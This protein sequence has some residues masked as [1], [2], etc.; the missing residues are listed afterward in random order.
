M[1]INS[2]MSLTHIQSSTMAHIRIKRFVKSQGPYP[3]I[4]KIRGSGTTLKISLNFELNLTEP[5]PCAWRGHAAQ[6]LF[7]YL[8][9][10][11][12]PQR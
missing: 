6:T 9:E 1:I 3:E 10:G 2:R 4:T 11:I 12:R 5:D 8:C 7:G